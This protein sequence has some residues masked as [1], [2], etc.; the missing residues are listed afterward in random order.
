MLNKFNLKIPA[1]KTVAIVG[2]SGNGKSTV[3]ALLERYVSFLKLIVL[4]FEHFLTEAIHVLPKNF[5]FLCILMHQKFNLKQRL[6]L[7]LIILTK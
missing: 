2:A 3:V 7:I 4:T 5:L 1:G 6:K